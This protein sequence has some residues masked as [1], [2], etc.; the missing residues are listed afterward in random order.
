M[1]LKF[2]KGMKLDNFIYVCF[3]CCVS[4]GDIRIL[5]DKICMTFF[6]TENNLFL[7]AFDSNVERKESTYMG[8]G[9]RWMDIYMDIYIYGP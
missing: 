3:L 4:S 8:R 9:L 5:N 2:E 7:Y 6:L 1:I